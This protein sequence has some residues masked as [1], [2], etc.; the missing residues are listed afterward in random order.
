MRYCENCGVPNEEDSR[1]CVSCGQPIAAESSGTLTRSVGQV[2]YGQGMPNDAVPGPAMLSQSYYGQPVAD[3]FEPPASAPPAFEPQAPFVPPADIP[4]APADMP[5]SFETSEVPFWQDGPAV[6]GVYPMDGGPAYGSPDA[7]FDQFAQSQPQSQLQP[8]PQSEVVPDTRLD[9]MEDKIDE[10]D[11]RLASMDGKIDK[12]VEQFADKISR[13]EHEASALK[14][15]S[16]E[17]EEYRNGLYEK[18][19]MPLVRDIIEVHKGLKAMTAR[20]EGHKIPVD[21]VSVF[22]DMLGDTLAKNSIEVVASE[23]GDEFLSFKHKMVGKV[24]TSD[25][26]LHGRIAEVE[27]ESYRLGD[28]Y[29]APALVKIYTLDE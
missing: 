6:G 19:T 26:S 24:K 22:A 9:D 5:E 16:A 4:A 17:I 25:S 28:S 15:V 21:E 11:E 10:L 7:G 29:I 2:A 8:Q 14:Q 27:G 3:P 12:L 20:Y 13:N 18:L 23:P 1:F